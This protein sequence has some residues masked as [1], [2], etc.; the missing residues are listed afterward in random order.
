MPMA[1]LHNPTESDFVVS[2]RGK[3]FI[4]CKDAEL[5]VGIGDHQFMLSLDY[6]AQTVYLTDPKTGEKLNLQIKDLIIDNEY[7]SNKLDVVDRIQEIVDV[8]TTGLTFVDS[9]SHVSS[10]ED[11][12]LNKE[13][14]Y[15]NDL[16]EITG[17]TPGS[18]IY[19]MDINVRTRFQTDPN[20]DAW[21]F[22][23]DDDGA[24]ILDEESGFPLI[25]TWIIAESEDHYLGV[26]GGNGSTVLF[27]DTW[28]DPGVVGNYTTNLNYTV[29]SNGK[30]F[31]R[32][33]M[34]HI[35]SGVATLRI[36]S[37]RPTGV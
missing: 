37:Y 33:N 30:L 14:L 6:A 36:Y 22:I 19:K 11:F 1:G 4:L 13:N 3:Q 23:G 16:V 31:V 35:L 5:V 9:T 29:S 7:I 2:V 17:F 18:V 24:Y 15:G 32:H 8:S 21:A 27:P 25:D 12:I 34:R 28:N 20:E 10:V 26:Y